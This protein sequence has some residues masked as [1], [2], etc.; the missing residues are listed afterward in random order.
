MIR[1]PS[2]S[3]GGRVYSFPTAGADLNFH[4]AVFGPVRMLDAKS[5]RSQLGRGLIAGNRFAFRRLY[6]KRFIRRT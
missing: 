2:I 3:V 4:I 6:A 1:L 5:P